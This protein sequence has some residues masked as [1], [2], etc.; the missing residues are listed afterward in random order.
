MGIPS[1]RRLKRL[2]TPQ[3]FYTWC[4]VL[5]EKQKAEGGDKKAFQASDEEKVKAWMKRK[6]MTD[7]D[8][9]GE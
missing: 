6:G 7:E 4:W 3:E 2:I 5:Q 9:R 8:D 1:V